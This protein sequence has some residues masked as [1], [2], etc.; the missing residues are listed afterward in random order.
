MA[1]LACDER[2]LLVAETR[3]QRQVVIGC[4]VEK[5]GHINRRA[6]I[7]RSGKAGGQKAAAF[8]NL[9]A[10]MCH[11]GQVK[12][13]QAK[14][15]KPRMAVSD[16]LRGAIIGDARCANLP[17]RGVIRVGTFR[18]ACVN[19]IFELQYR[20][21]AFSRLRLHAPTIRGFQAQLVEAP[22]FQLIINN[23][24]GG[25]YFVAIAFGQAHHARDGQLRFFAVIGQR[26]G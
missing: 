11:I 15:F 10:G 2:L 23:R 1:P 19:R 12:Y 24:I 5:I 13:R 18:A 21:I 6:E 4:K 3:R 26:L 9:R 16:I 20:A 25:V 14:N 8:V 17:K 22:L 7:R